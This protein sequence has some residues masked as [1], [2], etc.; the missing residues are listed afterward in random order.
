MLKND[1]PFTLGLATC[2]SAFFCVGGGGGGERGKISSS[3]RYRFIG[4]RHNF[5][6]KAVFQGVELAI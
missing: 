4:G 3:N 2:D 6:L 5:R 1:F